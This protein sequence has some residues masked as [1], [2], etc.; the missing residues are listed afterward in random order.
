MHQGLL[1]QVLQVVAS[2]RIRATFAKLYGRGMLARVVVDECHCV[3]QWGHDFRKD[4][5]C[6]STCFSPG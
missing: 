5:T 1:L 4:Y 6:E 3:S 2:N